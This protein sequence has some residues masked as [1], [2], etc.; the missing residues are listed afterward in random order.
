MNL[1]YTHAEKRKY[2]LILLVGLAL[3]L[4][5]DIL[6]FF[7]GMDNHCYDLFFRLRGS[8]V[9]DHRILIAAVDERTL[10]RLGRW[11]LR[12][13]HY[14]RLLDRLDKAKIVG[15]DILMVEPSEDDVV[16]AEA[17]GKNGRVILPAYIVN[18]RQ[19]ADTSSSFIPRGVGHIH[20]EQDID[21]VVRKVYHTLYTGGK[22]IP[23][24]ASTIYETLTGE[25]FPRDG[26]MGSEGDL[27]MQ[28]RII[29][30]D[31][32]KINYY[33]PPG[34]FPR[35]SLIDII[36]GRYPNDF[37]RDTIVLIGVTA[38]GLEAGVL[39]PFTQNR[40]LMTGV[41]THGHILANLID[42]NS[43][44]DVPDE[45]RWILSFCFALLGFFLFLRA[46]CSRTVLL[47]VLAILAAFITT[48]AV[49]VLSG[50]WFSPILFSFSLSFLLAVAYIF[51]LE[52]TGRRLGEAKE[53][54]EKSF[55]TISDA[56]V[57]TDC[58]GT[59]ARMNTAAKT[60]LNPYMLGLLS[61]RCCLQEEAQ[62]QASG[63]KQN[64]AA[65]AAG[66]AEAEEILDPATDRNF[67]VKSLPRFDPAGRSIGF[68]HVVR[69][70]TSRKK[71]EEEKEKLQSQLL[72]AQKMEAVGT[73]AGGI[74]HDFNNIL[75]GIQGY[76]SIMLL[77]LKLDH[78]FY[79]KFRKVEELVDSGA[80]LTRQLLGFARGG[81]YEVRPTN[82][83]DVL[84]KSS[85]T[86][87]H[88]HKE[89]SVSK[90][91][92]KELW[93]VAIDRR[94]FEQV[95]LNLYINACQAMPGGGIFVPGNAECGP[96]WPGCEA[97]WGGTG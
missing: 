37:F 84:E 88:T 49:F 25:A 17:I 43:L 24:F 78:P 63:D 8:A 62:S 67:E 54:W 73:L 31:A 29:Q 33:G 7:V 27:T 96:Q 87:S 56:I 71:A 66:D 26:R 59:A 74:A 32:R 34:T 15:F 53:E 55:N 21:G 89:T 10:D 91:L 50:V 5:A 46:E 68:V 14:A 41:E 35:L 61:G 20:L 72:R 81:K 70:I 19:V 11:P 42:R 93:P 83:N 90:D 65:V 52:R 38:A 58:Q 77:D 82:L 92:Q 64:G 23:S 69:D 51:R 75:A 80:S 39:T 47:W 48:F 13:S 95:L 1:H 3:I 85:E 60:L 94:Q 28:S 44:V 30:G 2:F 16:L 18:P 12:R 86:F 40:D 22:K 45:I 6:G 79:T 57:L 36:D 97:P 4:T 76:I 9:H